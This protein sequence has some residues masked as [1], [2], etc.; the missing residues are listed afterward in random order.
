VTEGLID[1][2]SGE[3]DDVRRLLWSER[4]LEKDKETEERKGLW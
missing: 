2:A 4:A 3:T 1:L